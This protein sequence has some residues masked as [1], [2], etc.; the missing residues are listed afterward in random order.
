[1]KDETSI[2]KIRFSG[3]DISPVSFTA[4][5]LGELLIDLQKGMASI[6]E[7]FGEFKNSMS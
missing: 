5:E 4:K 1:L 2:L 6:A 3:E 7:Q